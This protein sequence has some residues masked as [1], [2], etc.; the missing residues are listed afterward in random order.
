MKWQFLSIKYTKKL[1]FLFYPP[2]YAFINLIINT[3]HP[4]TKRNKRD[5]KYDISNISE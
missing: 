1:N 5:T 2:L 4:L 3:L